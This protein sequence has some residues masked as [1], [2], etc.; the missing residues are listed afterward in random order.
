[1]AGCCCFGG[2]WAEL[3][4]PVGETDAVEAEAR[5]YF[6]EHADALAASAAGDAGPSGSGGCAPGL[7][8]LAMDA[9][10]VIASRGHA[11]GDL[12]SEASLAPG[13]CFVRVVVLVVF[14][15][16][17]WRAVSMIADTFDGRSVRFGDEVPY[18]ADLPSD[19]D[20]DWGSDELF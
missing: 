7:G 14:T 16:G 9:F 6:A 4:A 2:D 12:A 18:V 8:A 17:A 3:T 15:A 11:G 20:S 10:V 13:R 1:M 5:R 19:V